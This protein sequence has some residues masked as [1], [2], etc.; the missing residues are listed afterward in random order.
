MGFSIAS[1]SGETREVIRYVESDPV[2][3][4]IP[5][6]EEQ[7]TDSS[8]QFTPRSVE[9][10][11]AEAA[12]DYTP[13]IPPVQ[14]SGLS[15]IPPVAPPQQD[16]LNPIASKHVSDAKS[17]HMKGDMMRALL[18]LEEAAKLITPDT[19]HLLYVKA[20]IHEDMGLWK[21]ASDIYLDIYKQ[22]TDA[23]SYYNI[24]A[25][26][27]ARG[28][29][30]VD[31]YADIINLGQIIAR[32][33]E[34]LKSCQLTIPIRSAPQHKIVPEKV[35]IDVHFYD[36][37]NGQSIEPASPQSKRLQSW[38]EA[39]IDWMGLGEETLHYDYQI[40]ENDISEAS[41]YGQREYYGQVIELYYR[42]QLVDT[43][44]SPRT[45]HAEHAKFKQPKASI[46]QPHTLPNFN[47]ENPILPALPTR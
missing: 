2:V 9:Q 40:S 8:L 35:R 3:V 41:I 6:E 16:I 32:P 27:L 31:R 44:A 30:T 23:G 17:L 22:G 11:I 43:H 37:S 5:I 42:D 14:T 38:G 25:K 46:F 29:R 15:T 12:G 28:L 20:I 19:P 39:P 26:K 1:R 47:P 13:S 10:I 45:L 34:D 24:A 21:E 18:K 33:A 4:R 7:A 36:T